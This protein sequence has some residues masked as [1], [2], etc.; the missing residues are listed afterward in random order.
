MKKFVLTALGCVAGWLALASTQAQTSANDC[1]KEMRFGILPSEESTAKTRYTPV[2]D[3][4]EAKLGTKIQYTIGAD[5]AA[6]II[7]MVNKRLELAW[8]GPESYVQ[9]AKQAK[10]HPLVMPDNKSTGLGYYSSL[11][12][13]ADSSYRSIQDLKGKTLAFVDPNSTSGYLF[14]MV[15][16]LKDLKVNPSDYFGQV[17]FAGNHNA[18]MLS[19]V[20][21]KVDVAAIASGTVTNAINAKTIKEGELRAV[22]QSRLIPNSP[23]TATDAVPGSCRARIQKAFLDLRDQKILDQFSAKRFVTVND[24]TYN[25]VREADRVK[26]ELRKK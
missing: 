18:S 16:F 11:F 8:L 26:E 20:N 14:P 13:R 9:A 19:L 6:I 5:Y 17:I 12:V 25:V 15:Y 7:A 2:F 1:P 24:V 4:L 22:W 23:I 3:Y 10:M 21:G